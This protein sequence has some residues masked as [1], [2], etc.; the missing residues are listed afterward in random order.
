MAVSPIE[1][2]KHLKG[3]DY[4]ADGEQLARTAA[5]QGAPEEEVDALKKHEGETFNGPNAVMKAIEHDL[6]G[7]DGG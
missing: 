5:E 1:V 3:V 2:Q 7:N 4:P 6:G